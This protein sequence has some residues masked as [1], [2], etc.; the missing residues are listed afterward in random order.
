MKRSILIVGVCILLVLGVVG[1][2]APEY[3][4]YN[5]LEELCK[6]AEH[7]EHVKVSGV[8]KLP[9]TVISDDWYHVLL[10]EDISQDQ[11]WLG[12]RISKGKSNNR[13]EPLPDNYTYDDFKVHTDDGRIVGHGDA[14]TVSGR[15]MSGCSL[16]VDVIE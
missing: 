11:P 5:T 8:L 13:M 14:A 10:V 1:C 15:Y 3:N 16:I 7:N 4:E 9:E 12:L 6:A 2:E